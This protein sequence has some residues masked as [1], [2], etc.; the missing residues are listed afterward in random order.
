MHEVRNRVEFL[1]PYISR[2]DREYGS[3]HSIDQSEVPEKF[4]S[5]NLT[6]LWML[7]GPESQGSFYGMAA[8]IDRL[9]DADPDIE[10]DRRLQ[11]LEQRAERFD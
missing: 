1:R 6:V 8:I 7:C 3:L 11:W 5:E 4:P 9:I 10:I 2:Y